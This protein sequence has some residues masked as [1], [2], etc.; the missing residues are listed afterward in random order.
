MSG[1][2]EDKL[3]KTLYPV[4]NDHVC[5]I[6]DKSLENTNLYFFA[7]SQQYFKPVVIFYFV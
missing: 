5:F 4:F 2:Q 7:E 1:N 3:R 6:I